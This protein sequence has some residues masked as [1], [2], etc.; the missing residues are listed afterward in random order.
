MMAVLSME[1]QIEPVKLVEA[2]TLLH[3]PVIVSVFKAKQKLQLIVYMYISLA[4]DCGPL[5]NTA[6]GQ[7]STS[8]QFLP[9]MLL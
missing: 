7:V 4:V 6:N 3:L 1:H 5:N 9:C 2:G 8:N